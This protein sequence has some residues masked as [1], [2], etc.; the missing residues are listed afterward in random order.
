VAWRGLNGPPA[1]EQA[2]FL[3]DAMKGLSKM[4]RRFW[5]DEQGTESL[6]WALICGIIVLAGAAVYGTI[7]TNLTTLWGS[8]NTQVNTAAAAAP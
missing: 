1:Q 4:V 6:E 5:T 3:G 7:R 2:L 8:V